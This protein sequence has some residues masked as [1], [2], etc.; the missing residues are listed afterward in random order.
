M[1]ITACSLLLA[2]IPMSDTGAQ[3]LDGSIQQGEYQHT[4]QMAQ[5]EYTLSWST[6]GNRITFGMSARTEG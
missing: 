1:G 4:M 5:G 3:T 6:D 2:A